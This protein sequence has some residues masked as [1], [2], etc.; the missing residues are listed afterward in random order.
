MRCSSLFLISAGSL[1]WAVKAEA[2]QSAPQIDQGLLGSM[3]SF[4][5]QSIYPTRQLHNP[6]EFAYGQIY[7]TRD[8]Q[9]ADLQQYS[10]RMNQ[11]ASNGLLGL[12]LGA[13]YSNSTH[14]VV[15]AT[16]SGT[17]ETS[18]LGIT[19]VSGGF[20]IEGPITG[21][22]ALYAEYAYH[23][24][25]FQFSTPAGVALIPSTDS[26]SQ[27]RYGLRFF[28][29]S[30]DALTYGQTT[31][32]GAY[33]APLNQEFSW[34]HTF[35]GNGSLELAYRTGSGVKAWQVGFGVGF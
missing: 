4:F 24:N 18:S 26:F 20:Y 32:Q 2:Q 28:L 11:S 14:D 15:T 21:R 29:T 13:S 33:L 8:A 25:K 10:F 6:Y 19:G 22:F 35:T 9:H 3:Q 12:F 5:S 34:K 17:A 23:Y 31:G 16:S 30:S 1:V 27:G 7:D